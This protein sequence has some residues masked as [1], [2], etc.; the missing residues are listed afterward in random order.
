M[1]SIAYFDLNAGK[2]IFQ[3]FPMYKFINVIITVMS[4][5]EIIITASLALAEDLSTCTMKKTPDEQNYC[6]AS[7]AGSGTFCDMIKMERKK[8]NV[9]L[10]LSSFKETMPI[11][12]RNTS[13][14]NL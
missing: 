13:H 9:N 11:R 7:F 5:V 3:E 12:L 10:W 4:A 6:K 14:Q 8:E 2:L 1:K